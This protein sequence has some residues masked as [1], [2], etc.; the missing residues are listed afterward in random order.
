LSIRLLNSSDIPAAMR[1]KEAAGWNQTEDDWRTLLAIAPDSCFC[2]E[3]SG[4]VA[5][6]TTAVVYGSKLA[7]IGM[8]LTAPEFRKRGFAH[9]LLRHTLDYLR[10]HEIEWAKLDAT[11]MGAPVYS[12]FD[13]QFECRVE[14]W[15]RPAGAPPAAKNRCS[16]QAV[17]ARAMAQRDAFGVSREQLLERLI[18]EGGT[19]INESGFALWRPGSFAHYFGPCVATS[20]GAAEQLLRNCLRANAGLPFVWD[21]ATQNAAAVELAE[22]YGFQRARTLSRMECA[23]RPDVTPLRPDMNSIF[24]LAGFEFG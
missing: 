12:D 3:C 13:F 17:E 21:L 5:A 16:D 14:R 18:R 20:S 23:L 2:V 1:L 10:E 22:A 11:E 8:V 7:W 19:S 4:Q 15:S 24:A 9:M 6:T